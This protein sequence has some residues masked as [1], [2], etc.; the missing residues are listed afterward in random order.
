MNQSNFQSIMDEH[1]RI[2][3]ILSE[4]WSTEMGILNLSGFEIFH[5]TESFTKLTGITDED[6]KLHRRDIF[7]HLLHPKERQA[8]IRAHTKTIL[9]YTKLYQ[10]ENHQPYVAAHYYFKLRKKDGSYKSVC[11]LIHP[12]RFSE[13]GYPLLSYVLFLP[14][15]N[16]GFERFSIAIR[17]NDKKLYYS[18]LANKYVQKKNLE[19]KEVEIE[20]LKLTAKGHGENKIAK[21]LDIKLDLVRYY[22]KSIY[23]KFYV[24]SMAE[25][26]YIALQN[27]II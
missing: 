5:I 11:T 21:L 3:D 13:A 8:V 14:A 16:S 1:V 20:I 6:I 22:K 25:A 2:C 26:V 23:K 9:F 24:S 18:L 27:N 12:I 17:N 7:T 19:L 4:I 15:C 10:K